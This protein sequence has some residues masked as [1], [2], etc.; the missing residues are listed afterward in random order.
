MEPS[1]LRDLLTA[2]AGLVTGALSAAFGI[3]GT[4]ISTPAL[5]ALGVSAITAIGTTL[6]SV[7]PSAIAGTLRYAKQGLVD[8]R[9]VR[10]VI[11]AGV[12]TS[13][14][15]SAASHRIPGDGHLLMLA[16]A[17]LL[18][19]TAVRTARAYDHADAASSAP[20]SSS[21]LLVAIGAVA[22]GLS[23]LLGVG[24]GI[25]M[26]PGF[27]DLA[28]LRLKPAIA[29]SLVCVGCFAIPGTIT[30]ALLGGVDWRYA[31]LLTLGVVPGARLGAA[32]SLRASDRPLRR[33]VGGFLGVV[34]VVYF[35]GELVA[36]TAQ[37]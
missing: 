1:L 33:L 18:A 25:V 31:G 28:R 24:G 9:A 13:V 22:G 34:A 23:G 12:V 3:G 27:T 16:T 8:W 37:D 30:H 10:I 17:A 20:Q 14:L 15:G 21:I 4:V 19:V 5:R 2:V 11:P 7:I 35:V 6:P 36:L 26:V 29:T 32:L